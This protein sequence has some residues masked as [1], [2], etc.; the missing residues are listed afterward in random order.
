MCMYVCVCRYYI[1]LLYYYVFFCQ[2]TA[3]SLMSLDKKV[4]FTEGKRN[5]HFVTAT[6]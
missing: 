3:M 1:L 5:H 2:M 6:S 4:S